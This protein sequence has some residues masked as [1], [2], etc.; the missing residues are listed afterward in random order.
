MERSL[1]FDIF[2][3]AIDENALWLERV[4]GLENAKRRMGE[5]AKQSRGKYF[6]FCDFSHTVV[7]QTDTSSETPSEETAVRLSELGKTEVASDCGAPMRHETQRNL[8]RGLLED[9]RCI[10]ASRFGTI[11]LSGWGIDA[12]NFDV[13]LP[14][15][16]V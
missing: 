14:G 10:Q 9:R 11:P 6:V 3:G 8:R 2:S 7:A 15:K 4:E 1:K 16:E 13:R 12:A 5:I